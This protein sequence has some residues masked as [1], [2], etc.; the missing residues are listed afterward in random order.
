M[1]RPTSGSKLIAACALM[2]AGAA[3]SSSANFSVTNGTPTGVA[4]STGVTINP[5][6]GPI[7]TSSPGITGSV[8][9]GQATLA[10]SGGGISANATL[11]QLASPAVWAPPPAG[12]D[13]HWADAAGSQSLTLSGTGFTGSAPTSSTFGVSF[14]VDTSKGSETFTSSAGECHVDLLQTA[15]TNMGGTFSCTNLASPLG[16]TVIASGSF[17]ATG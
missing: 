11:T 8:N 15:A 5:S 12:V 3:C 13:L 10:V 9:K 4:G 14:T 16:G 1:V 2:I 17:S 6:G 7:P